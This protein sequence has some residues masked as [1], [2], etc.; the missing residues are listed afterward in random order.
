MYATSVRRILARSNLMEESHPKTQMVLTS[1]LSYQTL[2][3]V[4]QGNITEKKIPSIKLGRFFN[5]Y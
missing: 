1:V 5:Y 3:I 4:H 2:R